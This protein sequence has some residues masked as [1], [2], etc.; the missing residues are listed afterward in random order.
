MSGEPK[1]L[2]AAQEE[3]FTRQRFDSRFPT[4]AVAW[5]LNNAGIQP[6]AVTDVVFYEQP[7]LKFS[8]L[9]DTFLSAGSCAFPGFA[10][11]M[12][13]WLLGK[14]FQVD[15][16]V[17]ELNKVGG[18]IDWRSRLSMTE[19]HAA[20]AASAFFPSP[21]DE[22]LVLTVDGV[23]E[24][25]TTAV[26]MGSGNRLQLLKENRFP[27]S[28]GLLYSAFTY[29]T[30]FKVNSGE[31][32]MMGLSP[33]GKPVFKDLIY[34]TLLD[35]PEDGSFW[36]NPDYFDSFANECIINEKF[37]ELLGGPAR[38]PEDLLTQRD[39]DLAASIQAV[40]EEVLL[41]M[42]QALREQTGARNLCLAGGVALNCV[43]NGRI[44]REG[45]FDGVWVQPAAGDA[46]GAL[47]AA[48]YLCYMEHNCRRGAGTDSMQGAYLG[49]SFSDAEMEASLRRYN[50]RFEQLSKD[51]LIWSCAHALAQGLTVG[52][53]QGRMEFGPRA[54]GNRSILADSRPIDTQRTL[55]LK[56]KKRESFRPFAPAV[57]REHVNDW[58]DLDSDSP[59][60]SFVAR[61]AQKRLKAAD[62]AVE[63]PAGRFSLDGKHSE[64]PAVTHVDNTARIQT[65]HEDTNPLFYSLVQE[66]YRQTGCPVIVNTSFNVRGEPIVCTP[67]DAYKCFM[68][69]SLDLL[70]MGPFLL[71]KQNQDPVMAMKLAQEFAPD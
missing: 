5:C 12:P 9:V 8:R 34:E 33:Y 54:L 11:A 37:A 63:R 48:L 66:F 55:N 22:A 43:A 51:D 61:V 41:H 29:Y 25:A 35:V 20:H 50:A 17:A 42:T 32:K 7:L 45:G 67:D 57:L 4:Q 21:Y 69:T 70:A 27:H 23:G 39:A 14:I 2:G 53:F 68:N 13:K 47:G 10:E 46:G 6:A 3:R 49:P 1:I 52:W 16:L 28:L 62:G 40:T 65:I 38:G 56:I 31:Y 44:L 30:G 60:M 64:I 19:H 59:Y 58:F 71:S 24:H 15:T 26:S 18:D 36:V